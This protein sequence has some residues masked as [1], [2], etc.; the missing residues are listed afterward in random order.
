MVFSDSC[1]EESSSSICQFFIKLQFSIECVVSTK[2]MYWLATHEFYHRVIQL[3]SY[4][5]KWKLIL[6]WAKSKG[7]IFK[8]TF[9]S[10]NGLGWKE[11]ERSSGS[12]SP[13]MDK[14]T[15][16][17]L[18][19]DSSNLALNSSRDGTSTS[20]GNLFHCHHTKEFLPYI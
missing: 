6:S 18:L 13:A 20:L 17:R 16:T 9:E 1:L 7:I 12:R 5:I 10:K 11:P 4:I 15:E 19:S 3:N 8:V 14:D 2:A